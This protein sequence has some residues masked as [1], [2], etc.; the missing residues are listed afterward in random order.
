MGV[1]KYSPN[2]ALYGDMGWM[3]CIIKQWSC[4]F[5]TW[6]R[7]T[8]MCNSTLN[9]KV[10]LWGKVH[11]NRN[12]KNWN[13]RVHTK[14]K[15][16]DMEYLCNTDIILDK[17][18]H[19]NIENVSFDIYKRKWH[20]DLMLNE[21]SKLRT[22]RL[23]KNEYVKEEYFSVNMPGKY[24]CSFAKLR[25][26]VA[27]LKIESGRYEG[28]SIENRTC[29]NNICN[30]DNCIENEKHVYFSVQYMQICVVIYLNML[31]FFNNNC[32]QLSDEE[33]FLFLFSDENICFYSAK[34]CHYILFK[35]KCILY[36]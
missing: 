32:M 21:C 30:V 28:V 22:Y 34:I 5:R 13:F 1:G 36:R 24:K 14:F 10:F 29:F 2:L 8:N 17:N 35:R 4:N 16:L 25:C 33:F 31:V 7:F 27:P 18:V 6:S 20:D 26:G 23:F 12:L 15:E 9:K 19:K 11:C 3:P